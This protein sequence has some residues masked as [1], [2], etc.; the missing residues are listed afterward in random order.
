MP[1]RYV[2]VSQRTAAHLAGLFVKRETS[3]DKGDPRGVIGIVAACSI[4][5]F[6]DTTILFPV[7]CVHERVVFHALIDRER[8][9]IRLHLRSETSKVRASETPPLAGRAVCPKHS[10]VI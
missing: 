7:A 6:V 9:R 5:C 10:H 4:K 3:T 2:S 8:G 1:A